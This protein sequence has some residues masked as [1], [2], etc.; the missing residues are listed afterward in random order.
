VLVRRGDVADGLE[1]LRSTLPEL[2]ETSF[3]PDYPVTFALAEGLAAAGQ[4]AKA[5]VT[6]DEA[7]AKSE[8]DEVDRGSRAHQGRACYAGRGLGFRCRVPR[9]ISSARWS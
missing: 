6:I 4:I 3:V 8:R 2:R 1:L 9:R 5:L 7:L